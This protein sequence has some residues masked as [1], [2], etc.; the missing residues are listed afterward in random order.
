MT[1]RVSLR[2]AGSRPTGHRR[3]LAAG[4][5]GDG[6]GDVHWQRGVVCHSRAQYLRPGGGG[7]VP[8]RQPGLICTCSTVGSR[9][10]RYTAR[11]CV[12]AR[13]A[14]LSTLAT[15]MARASTLSSSSPAVFASAA[16]KVP[17]SHRRRG[18]AHGPQ[19]WA[20]LEMDA[21]AGTWWW[22]QAAHCAKDLA[23]VGG[24]R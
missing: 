17:P 11:C 4:S 5:G 16:T 6:L 3:A 19:E 10:S 12:S 9:S 21:T 22:P 24:W 8:V 20:Q 13:A 7:R 2:L 18:W 15:R 23:V 1:E 14:S